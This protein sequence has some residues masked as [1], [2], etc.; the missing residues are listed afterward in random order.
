[1]HTLICVKLFET[2]DCDKFDSPEVDGDYESYLSIDYSLDC[3]SDRHV[4]FEAYAISMVAFYVCLIPAAMAVSKW[5]QVSDDGVSRPGLLA[6]PYKKKWWFFDA[7]DIYY[8]LSMTGFLLIITNKVEIRIVICIF[9]AACFLAVTM[10]SR[11]WATKSHNEVMS[12]GQF[13][14]SLVVISGYIVSTIE[15]DEHLPMISWLLLMSN[16][17]IILLTM[18][19]QRK[20]ALFRVIAALK[21]REQFDHNEFSKL[22]GG[23]PREALS[24]ALLISCSRCIDTLQDGAASDEA[25]D[26]AW[27]FILEL[28]A[29]REN[30]DSF[31]FD[32]LAPKKSNWSALLE[33]AIQQ[34]IRDKHREGLKRHKVIYE[35]WCRKKGEINPGWKRRYLLLLYLPNHM[36]PELCWFGKFP[37]V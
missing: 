23:T 3:K 5:Q 12:T 24:S 33:G 35:G 28:F 22:W 29:F 21:H 26:R 6:A 15:N 4:R 1:M 20:E 2:F 10:I 14:V 25:A 30:G 37:T 13:V 27:A 11:P 8:R 34:Q 19:Q 18:L 7:L 9:F 32:S 36:K 16:V 17:S 31:V